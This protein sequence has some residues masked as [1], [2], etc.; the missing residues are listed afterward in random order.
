MVQLGVDLGGTGIKAG[1][2]ENGRILKKR[3]RPTGA[4]DG[5]EAVLNR[6][7]ALCREVAGE[8]LSELPSVGLG[9]PGV[10]SAD[11]GTVFFAANLGFS[12]TPLADELQKRLPLPV[13]V[14]NDANCAALAES[15]YGAAA[16]CKN[17][18]LLTLGTGVGGGVI[19]DGKILSGANC[20]AGELGHMTIAMDG[21]RCTCGRRGCLEAYASATALV[22]DTRRAMEAHPDS[23]LWETAAR[24]EAGLS[25]EERL[26]LVNG[27]T[28]FLAAKAGDK[29]AQAVVSSYIHALAEGIA[30][31][32]N[33]FRPEQILLGGGLSH[34]G[35]PLI[36]PLEREVAALAFGGTRGIPIPP[37]RRAALGNDA[38]LIGASLL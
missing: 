4:A 12:H 21:E 11:G 3:S 22:R 34:E 33:L 8:R 26:A 27:R 7:A 9:T 29:A 10:L 18:V 17:V 30:N 6:I 15:R 16:G 37:I 23:A 1:L 19:V 36:L 35:D 13:R 5:V 38:G 20:S 14:E 25:R 31:L 24:G 32:V 28:A 2:V